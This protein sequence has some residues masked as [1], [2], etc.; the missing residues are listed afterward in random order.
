MTMATYTIDHNTHTGFN[1]LADNDLWTIAAGTTV[2]VADDD[3][4]F[5]IKS[6]ESNSFIVKGTVRTTG[7]FN[8]F[9]IKASETH[10]TI[11]S[12]GVVES[13]RS[14]IMLLA[15]AS[16]VF[17]NGTIEAYAFG[18]RFM[19]D[20]AYLVNKG[21]ITSDN[22]GV[23]IDGPKSEVENYGTIEGLVGLSVTTDVGH[24]D[25]Y[26]AGTIEGSRYA[27][28]GSTAMETVKNLGEIIGDVYLRSG[29]DIFIS[30]G[31]SVTGSVFGGNGD[32]TFYID[33]AN[34]KLVEIK[35]GGTD[36]VFSSVSYGL[37]SF[38]ENLTLT[39]SQ[40]LDAD[41]NSIG[42]RIYGNSAANA[43]Y[44]LG[45]KDTLFG[46]A[47]D[48]RLYGGKGSDTIRSGSEN[49]TLF[50]AAGDDRLSG[51]TGADT[52][53]GGSGRDLINGGD[54]MD[55]ITGGKDNDRLNGG[56]AR[57]TF[58]FL[59][60]HGRDRVNDFVAKGSQHDILDLSGLSQIISLSDL[61]AH[62]MQQV[63]EDVVIV[64][65]SSRIVL[66][67]VDMADLTRSDFMF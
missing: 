44:G 50:G 59:D 23:N 58:V 16:K 56:L 39:G 6:F 29:A 13:A 55:R 63:G 11:T 53:S 14:A 38:I 22:T 20:G 37:A 36:A 31:G 24:F 60:D 46:N 4:F 43:I 48:D 54:G 45:G 51:G 27:Y 47:G 41:G 40:Q 62:H 57:D 3:A 15:N 61:R 5:G 52:I 65:D 7:D 42:N 25:L 10:I 19:D 8:A 66:K 28:V 67:D 32:D 33:K 64:D 12:G 1:T 9:N 2:D 35:T 49:D 18:V 21:T 17:N 30:D 26:N 34:L